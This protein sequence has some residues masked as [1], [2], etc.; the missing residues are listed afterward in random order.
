MTTLADTQCKGARFA[1]SVISVWSLRGS[2]FAS[3]LLM[4]SD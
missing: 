1:L 4:I 3:V 2:A